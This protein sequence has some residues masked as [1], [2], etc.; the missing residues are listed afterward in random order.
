MAMLPSEEEASQ[1]TAAP[2]PVQPVPDTVTVIEVCPLT[3][4]VQ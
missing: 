3:E 1:I 4:S 2:P